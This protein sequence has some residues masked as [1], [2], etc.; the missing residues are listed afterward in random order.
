MQK[1]LQQNNVILLHEIRKLQHSLIQ[2]SNNVPEELTGYTNWV[3]QVCESFSHSV[4]KNLKYL[5]SGRQDILEDILSETQKVSWNFYVFNKCHTSPVLRARSSDRLPLKLLLWLHATHPKTKGIPV[6]VCDGEF[7]ISMTGAT[8]YF[9]PCAAQHGL[10]NLPLYFHEFGHLLYGCHQRE[11]DDLVK[12]LQAEIKR[13]LLLAAV[14][15]DRYTEKRE[16]DQAII[17]AR[18]FTWSQEFFC[19]A[20]GFIMGGAAFTSAFSMYLRML[21]RSQYHMEKL[22]HRSHPVPWIRIQLLADRARQMGY[23]AVAAGLEDEW[24]QIAAA[25]GIVENHYYGFYHPTFLP[26][27]QQKLDDMLTEAAPREFQELEVAAQEPEP[28]F[29]S[30]V[31]LLNSAWLRFRDDPDNYQ[32][33]EEKA[34]S[35]FLDSDP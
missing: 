3:T 15:K 22:V 13:L 14:K 33:W 12:E 6:A 35:H 16:T 21:G 11:M 29:T 5:E 10:L 9:T 4:L 34:I 7:S 23:N 28:N 30:P 20:V 18:W 19:D 27:I 25:L 2:A 1:L 17:A 31:A 24:N 8:I 32:E 26:R